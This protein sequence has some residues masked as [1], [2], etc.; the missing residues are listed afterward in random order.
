MISL[1]MIM[2][3]VLAYGLPQGVLAK[4]DHSLQA[5]LFDRPD[6]SFGESVQ[7]WRTWRKPHRLGSGFGENA[8][9]LRGVERIAVVN[10]I[11]LCLQDSV[12][13]VGDVAPNLLHPQSIGALGDS[14]ELNVSGR[15][16]DEE[17]NHEALEALQ[18][19]DL[20][21]EEICGGNLI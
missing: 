13:T 14:A 6:E 15:E 12:F 18:G 5:F 19:P 17:E 11:M 20:H 3:K 10:K 9:E 21:G 7:V 2:S 4:E 16:L 1:L 8:K